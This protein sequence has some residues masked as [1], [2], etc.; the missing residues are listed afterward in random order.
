MS[1]AVKAAGLEKFYDI[2]RALDGVSFSVE[3]GQVVALLGPNGSGKT[4]ALRA[5]A[6]LLRLDGGSLTCLSSRC[7]RRT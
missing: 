5:V 2:V 7:S 1:A 4:T 6:G 3:P